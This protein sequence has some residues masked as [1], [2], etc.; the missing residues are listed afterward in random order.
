MNIP[1]KLQGC[2]QSRYRMWTVMGF[3]GVQ[4]QP[5]YLLAY[6][7]VIISVRMKVCLTACSCYATSCSLCQIKHERPAYLWCEYSSLQ[8]CWLRSGL[9]PRH[10]SPAVPDCLH[11]A[12]CGDYACHVWLCA[13]DRWARPRLNTHTR[14]RR[15]SGGDSCCHFSLGLLYT[16]SVS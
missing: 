7:Y 13:S 10:Y 8:L 16:K 2:L 1:D 9:I 15:D 4:A 3:H 12:G 11:A 14:S 5:R 6:D